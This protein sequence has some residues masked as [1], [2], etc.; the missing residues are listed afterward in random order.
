MHLE[1]VRKGGK[2]VGF[3]V[4]GDD[5]RAFGD[6]FRV[7][8]DNFVYLETQKEVMLAEKVAFR[9]FGDVDI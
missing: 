6:K 8:G 2:K 1:R 7:C 5:F 4:F 3:R 9:A